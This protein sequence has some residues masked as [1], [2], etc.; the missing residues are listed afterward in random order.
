MN[1]MFFCLSVD[2]IEA[3]MVD[4]KGNTWG[5]VV[6]ACNTINI[7]LVARGSYFVMVTNWMKFL[8]VNFFMDHFVK[9]RCFLTRSINILR[10]F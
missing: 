5:S 9:K 10:F 6:R 3:R 1:A 8:C 7:N 2:G 4:C